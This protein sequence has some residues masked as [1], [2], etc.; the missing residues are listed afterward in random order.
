MIVYHGSDHIIECPK[1]E[2]G[3]PTN[4]F[5]KGFYMTEDEDLAKEYAVRF[6]KNGYLNKYDLDISDLKLINLMKGKYTVLNWLALILQNREMSMKSPIGVAAKKYIV[7]NFEVGTKG[8]DVVISY[9]AEDS[10]FDFIEKFLENSISLKELNKALKFGKLK[11][12]F[13]LTSKKAVES[14]KFEGSEVCL[15]QDCYPKKLNRDNQTR[16][17]FEK[18]S[19][20][21]FDLND[22]YMIDILREEMKNDDTRISRILSE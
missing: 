18:Y 7:D 9:R 13:V 21:K 6:G 10:Y 2:L 17:E 4:D 1:Y 12:Q 22:I 14:L 15:K 19:S 8:Y 20:K 11:T 5:G 3:I 16:L